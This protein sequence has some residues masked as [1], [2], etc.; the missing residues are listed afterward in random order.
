VLAVLSDEQE[1][2]RDM[3]AQL[4]ASI[5]LRTTG[6][7][8]SLDRAQAWHRLSEAGLLGL[9]IRDEDG[10]PAGSGVEHLLIAMALGGALAPVPFLGSVLAAELLALGGGPAEWL[11]DIAAGQARYALLL[12]PDLCGLADIADVVGTVAWDAD[13]AAYAVALKRTPS[14]GRIVRVSITPGFSALESADLTRR[15][16]RPGDAIGTDQYEEASDSLSAELHERW[17]ALALTLVCGDVVGVMTSGLRDAVAYTRERIQYG[18]PVGSFQAVQHLCAECLVET[19]AAAATARYAAWA[20][21]ALD[22]PDALIAARTA[23]AY[24]SSAAREVTETIMQIYGG[25][26]HTWEHL[27]H[28]RTRRAL[29]DRQVLGDESE[30]LVRIADWRLAAHRP[31]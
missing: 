17:L 4:S 8:A 3:V 26:G 21:D 23:K 31:G 20:V 5:G 15:L 14:S 7:L 19:E 25:I 10:V 1:M 2:L 16:L 30:H 24:C 18:V 12:T 29:M 6:D 28:V 9:R 27:A 22:P 11:N 13:E